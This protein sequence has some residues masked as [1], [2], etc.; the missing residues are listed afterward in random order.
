MFH[1]SNDKRAVESAE[2]LR[3]ALSRLLKKDSF[4]HI[5]ITD[6][7]REA[8][9]SRTTF[10]RLFDTPCDIIRWNCDVAL[11]QLLDAIQANGSAA[12]EWPF[13]FNL[14]Y[15]LDHPEPL[16]LAYR[17]GRTDIADSTF[18]TYMEPMLEPMRKQHGVS[19]DD[20]RY[21]TIVVSSIITSVFRMWFDDGKRET[22][23]EVY[24]RVIRITHH[25][26]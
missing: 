2:Q 14:R 13:R 3:A 16:E 20:L 4:E 18:K 11:R 10:Y 26:R 23:A 22:P 21:S 25:L 12:S 5:G 9:V 17:A 7:C 24:E 8:G 6:L 19:E 1:F 15:I